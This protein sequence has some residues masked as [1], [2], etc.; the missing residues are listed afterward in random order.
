MRKITEIIVHCTATPYG[1]ETS[2]E[3]IDAWHRARGFKSIGYHFVIGLDGRVMTGRNIK[4][5]GAHCK[6][7]NAHSIG[8]CYVGGLDPNGKPADTRTDKQKQALRC[9]IED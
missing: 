7:H 1:R 6:G 8:I 5:P 9:K 2:V 3:E 4:E